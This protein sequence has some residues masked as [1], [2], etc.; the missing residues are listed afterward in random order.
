MKLNAAI[1][2]TCVL[3]LAVAPSSAWAQDYD[4]LD[5]PEDS[6]KPKKARKAPKATSQQVREIVKGTYAKSN[7][8]ASM[9]FGSFSGYVSPGTSLGLAVGQDFVDQ[10][11]LSAAWEV[12]FTQG[13]N[14][15]MDYVEQAD[16]AS[17][18]VPVP[19]VQGD[20]RTYT[21]A[22]TVEASTYPNR[23]LGIGIRAGGGVM[24]SPLLMSDGTGDGEP[25]DRP[26]YT[27]DV[28]GDAWGIGD[29]GY[30][31]GPHPVAMGGPTIEYY[32]KLSHF[33][34]GLDIDAFYAIGFDFG[35]NATGTLKYT[36]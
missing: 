35:A 27:E 29:P 12:H 30:H 2:A 33:S 19:F 21:I 18:G 5:S 25:Y 3:A 6:A 15:G 31:T 8:G 23:R 32:T 28:L 26:Y 24:F 13:I 36:F 16:L 14:N 34:V 17:Q 7:V 1:L 4:D 11:R 20:I 9:Y 10:E 22:A